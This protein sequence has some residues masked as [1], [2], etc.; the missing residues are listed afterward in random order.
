M[1]SR[2]FVI[3]DFKKLLC[4]FI[5]RLFFTQRKLGILAV[6]LFHLGFAI[7]AINTLQV[8]RDCCAVCVDCATASLI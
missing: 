8:S 6:A 5:R 3:V 7:G 1:R 4:V 2:C